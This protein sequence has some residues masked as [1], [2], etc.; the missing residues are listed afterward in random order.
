MKPK[1][2]DKL[3]LHF[4]RFWVDLGDKLRPELPAADAPADGASAAGGT[5]GSDWISAIG[6]AAFF[7]QFAIFPVMYLDADVAGA[8]A[9]ATAAALFG[10]CCVSPS[11]HCVIDA[12]HRQ[13]CA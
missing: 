10:H 6:R 3:E 4:D 12:A 1:G 13:S 9:C 2:D 11:Q 8:C 7:P 5:S